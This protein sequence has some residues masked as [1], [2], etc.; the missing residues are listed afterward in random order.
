LARKSFEEVT[1]ALEVDP[2][3]AGEPFW[4]QHAE[5]P[6]CAA[7]RLMCGAEIVSILL[8]HGASAKHENMHGQTPLMLLHSVKIRHELVMSQEWKEIELMLSEVGADIS[9]ACRQS[10]NVAGPEAIV[11]SVFH[12]APWFHEDL[13]LAMSAPDWLSMP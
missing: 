1:T 4:D 5:P 11:G 8:K 10:N 2:E 12:S 7:V 6:L 3:A 13:A 9:E